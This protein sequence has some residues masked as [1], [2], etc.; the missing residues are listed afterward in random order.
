M[1]SGTK[2]N[3]AQQLPGKIGHAEFVAMMAAMMSITALSIDTMLPALPQIGADLH[4]VDANDRQSIIT[5]F[6]IGLAV[7]SLFYGPLSDRFGRRKVLMLAAGLQL[8]STLICVM[9]TSFPVMLGARLLAGFS[10]ASCRVVSTS[11]VR[12]CFRGDAM[13]RV[14]S[15]IMMIFVMVPV[16]APSV[17]ALVLMFAPWRAIFGLLLICIV[18]VGLW[19][20]WRLPETLPPENRL[21]IGPKDLWATFVQIV[22]NRNSIGHMLASGIM[23]GGMIG[24]LVSIQQIFDEVF[25]ASQYF[26]IG[27]AAI[28][29][30]MGLGS[31]LNSRLVERFGARRL[32]QGAVITLVLMSLIHCAIVLSGYENLI[33]FIIVQAMTVVCFSFSGSNFGAISLEPFTKGA[34]LAASVQA[35]LT[36][37]I[38]TILGAL[39]GASFNGTV[40]PMTIGF[41]VFGAVALMVIAW[42]ERWKLFARPGHAALRKENIILPDK[43]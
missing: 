18:A 43:G 28:T 1:H 36:T 34:G 32:G 39:V 40:L 23:F 38:S 12:D 13:A 33:S 27:F 21:N 8:I 25:D 41:L 31:L 10:I 15:L 14:M 11:I 24:F 6:M 3:Q 22:T 19:Q 37:L 30:W 2:K 4:V 7:G 5:M 26:A 42:A 20:Y 35:C 9:A 17:G 16:L 29:I